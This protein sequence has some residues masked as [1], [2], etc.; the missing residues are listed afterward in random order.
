LPFSAY[1]LTELKV[2]QRMS[3]ESALQ[4]H[5]ITSPTQVFLAMT[6]NAVTAKN[7]ENQ[8]FCEFFRLCTGSQS[9]FRRNGAEEV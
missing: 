4:F 1:E 8:I 7:C 3:S 5:T 9:R 6:A 2:K